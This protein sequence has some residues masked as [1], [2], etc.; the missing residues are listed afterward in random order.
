MIRTAVIGYGGVARSHVRDIDFFRQDNPL[1]GADDP[2]VE[3]VACCDI[4]PQA[5]EAFA[6]DTGVTA[7]YDDVARM[8]D[9]QRPDYVHI[10]TCAD[11]HLEPVLACAQK[12][13]HVLCEKP[14]GTDPAECDQMIAACD[15]A[16][17]Q[18]VVSHQRQSC[19]MYWYAR[20]LLDE[21]VIG[22]L[23]YITGG[24][25]DPRGGGPVFHN[26]GS[27]LIDAIGIFRRD[28]QWVSGYCTVDGRPCTAQDRQ[29]GDRGA[30]WVLGDRIDVTVRYGDD[31]Q[32]NLQFNG[33]SAKVVF[34]TLWG[35]EGRMAM[36]GNTFYKCADPREGVA[37]QWE[38]IEEPAQPVKTGSGYINPPDWVHIRQQLGPYPRIFMLREMFQRMQSGGEHTSSGRV[39][40]IPIEV[41]QATFLSHL[42]GKKI[43]FPVQERRS[44]LAR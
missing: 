29:P 25:C 21:G 41:M 8:L 9:E 30:G 15:E 20:S 1:R 22:R 31:V 3:L 38:P 28:V 32:T 6:E 13:V 42:E 7:V 26:L 5:R 18:F 16:G 10:A 4:M 27:H 44:V 43:A 33:D 37:D 23:R 40:A 2:L 11:A 19:P 17:V 35:T 24:V 12:G 39:G 14:L 34:W 36:L